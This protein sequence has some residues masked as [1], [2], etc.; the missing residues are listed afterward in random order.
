MVC[1]AARCQLDAALEADARYRD[2][3]VAANVSF[4]FGAVALVGAAAWWVIARVTRPPSR[5]ATSSAG[6]TVA[7]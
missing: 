1:S 5:V 3:G 7:W 2:R 6:L 4:T